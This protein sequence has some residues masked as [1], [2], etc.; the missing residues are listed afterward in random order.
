LIIVVVVVICC[1]VAACLGLGY[2][3]W[4]NGDRLLGVSALLRGLAAA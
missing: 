1:L 4:T 2:Y 3:L